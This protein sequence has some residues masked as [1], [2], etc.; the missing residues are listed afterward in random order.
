MFAYDARAS[1]VDVLH[2]YIF[3]SSTP[4]A[5]YWIASFV[6]V[7][8]PARPLRARHRPRVGIDAELQAQPMNI[9][10]DRFRAVSKTLRV[11]NDISLR[12]RLTCRQT[13][14]LRTI[15][16]LSSTSPLRRPCF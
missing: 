5:A 11:G 15:L 13:S 1:C 4:Q 16:R 14:M 8:E 3:R 12:T 2:Q 6:F 9:V 7:P 10:A